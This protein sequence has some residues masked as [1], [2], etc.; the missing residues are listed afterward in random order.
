MCGAVG[1]LE[2]S[3]KSVNL[4]R[5]EEMAA[6]FKGESPWNVAMFKEQVLA[7]GVEFLLVGS[8]CC[9]SSVCS[10]FCFLPVSVLHSPGCC[11]SKL[12]FYHPLSMETVSGCSFSGPR[13]EEA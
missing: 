8:L 4:D 5:C 7:V 10:R 1:R 2:G 12:A 9:Y 11:L 6:H 13:A 3:S